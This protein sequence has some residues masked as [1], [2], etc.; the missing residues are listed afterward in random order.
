MWGGG[1]GGGGLSADKYTV[2]SYEVHFYQG[3][4]LQTNQSNVLARNLLKKGGRH[5]DQSILVFLSHSFYS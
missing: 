2:V 1:G 5:Q 3:V 4:M